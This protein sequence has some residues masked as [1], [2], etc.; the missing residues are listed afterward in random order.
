MPT[1][2]PST[3]VRFQL[4]TD[5]FAAQHLVDAQTVRK[6]LSSH[7]SYF[8]IKPLRLP[9]RRLLWP[10]DSITMLIEERQR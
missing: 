10:A 5:A 3:P 6:R 1:Q 2:P 9:N 4:T 8:D 7:G